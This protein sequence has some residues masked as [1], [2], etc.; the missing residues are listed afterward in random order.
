MDELDTRSCFEGSVERV[1]TP[2]DQLD[3]YSYLS[4]SVAHIS[5]L[6]KQMDTFSYLDWSIGHMLLPD[7]P[8]GHR[9]M[10]RYVSFL[11][12]YVCRSRVRTASRQLHAFTFPP[13]RNMKNTLPKGYVLD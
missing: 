1:I 13:S 2:T 3:M 5:Y 9:L 11:S 10:W 4:K 12:R 6:G 7:R 8:V